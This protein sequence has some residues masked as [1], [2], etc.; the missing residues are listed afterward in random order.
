MTNAPSTAP[1]FLRLLNAKATKRSK[2]AYLG[3]L[4]FGAQQIQ[5]YRLGN[6]LKVLMLE[7]H[8]AP[9]VSYNTWFRVGSRHEREGKTGLAHLFEHLMFN[10]TKNLGAGRFDKLLERAGA[11]TN[12][13]T[14]NDWTFY[15]ENVPADQLPLV[16]KLE[17]ERMANL[18]LR[19]GP[20]GSEKEVVANER[21]YR[22]EDDVS[23]AVAEVLW[24]EA[25]KVHP[26]HHPTIGWMADILNFTPADC[27]AFY[28]TWYAP[29]NATL[30][31]VGDVDPAKVLRAIQRAYGGLSAARL[32]SLD[33]Q[34]EPDQDG[35]RVLRLEKPTPTDKVA[36]G[37]KAPGLDHPD[38]A[39]LTLLSEA[40]LGSRASRFFHALVTEREVASDVS[41][42]ASTFRDPGLWEIS[43]TATPGQTAEALLG[44][45]DQL[46]DTLAATP[47]N[48][49]ERERSLAKQ[50]LLLLRG[51]DTVGGRAEQ[52]G[53]FDAVL[54]DPAGAFTRLERLRAVTVADLDRVARRYLVRGAR[55]VVLVKADRGLEGAEAA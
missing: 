53:F 30:V 40:L 37:Y 18:V 8:R 19:K 27:R 50:E 21:R 1:G 16:I 2:I 38:H 14:W 17:A 34:T 41:G 15:Y 51:L 39:A 10:E 49:D 48:A 52:I 45:I 25:F 46:V 24:A 6:G 22:V 9:I 7:D 32:P 44:A 47:I 23:G 28:K 26:Y 11:E 42:W 36:L 12:A 4:A 55:T 33:P 3:A 43:A 5:Q 20:V 35:E 13:A 54:D 29:N 31:I